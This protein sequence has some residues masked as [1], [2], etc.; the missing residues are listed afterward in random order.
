MCDVQLIST[1]RQRLPDCQELDLCGGGSTAQFACGQSAQDHLD[2]H[3]LSSA[4]IEV[5]GDPCRE[6]LHLD[7]MMSAGRVGSKVAT[8]TNNPCHHQQTSPNKSKAHF[9]GIHGVAIAPGP[10]GKDGWPP[11]KSA[12]S[13]TTRR[14][15]KASRPGGGESNAGEC[16]CMPSFQ[17]HCTAPSKQASK[18]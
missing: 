6:P 9:P 15:L 13:Q 5:S 7:Y 3:T 17:V 2:W 8:P 14:H 10:A 1:H 16:V 11:S 4:A 18:M 12:V